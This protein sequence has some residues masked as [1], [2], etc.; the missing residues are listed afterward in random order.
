MMTHT[1]WHSISSSDVTSMS[2]GSWR[3]T[4]SLHALDQQSASQ[5][6]SSSCFDDDTEMAESVISVSTRTSSD[7]GSKSFSSF[8]SKPEDQNVARKC[9]VPALKR[10]QVKAAAAGGDQYSSFASR[11][12]YE[13]QAVVCMLYDSFVFLSNASMVSVSLLL[14]VH[15]YHI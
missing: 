10:Q 7:N 15:S 11:R 2:A 1:Q 14:H 8:S 6:A 4:A 13:R 3:A 5:A 12:S 9:V